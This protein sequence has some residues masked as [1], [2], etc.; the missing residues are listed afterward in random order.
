MS[1]VQNVLSDIHAAYFSDLSLIVES[2]E[3]AGRAID[4]NSLPAM[5]VILPPTGTLTWRNG[6]VYDSVN[7]A[8]AFLDKVQRDANGLDNDARA[9]DMRELAAMLLKALNESG[10]VERIESATYTNI[11]ERKAGIVSGC[12]LDLTLTNKAGWCVTLPVSKESESGN[13]NGNE[14]GLNP[15]P[16][17]PQNPNIDPHP[18]NPLP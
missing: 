14:G 5:V 13:E 7:I 10:A 4:K 9:F 2:W 16:F 6:R 12:Y 8:V 1:Y 17:D 11:Y 18:F 3:D 15:K